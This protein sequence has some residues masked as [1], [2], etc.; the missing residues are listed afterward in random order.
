[1]HLSDAKGV[2]Q[3]R[4]NASVRCKGCA[5]MA[6]KCICQMQRVCRNGGEMH[7]T[8]AKGAEKFAANA[9]A[10]CKG[11]RFAGPLHLAGAFPQIYY[12]TCYSW[13]N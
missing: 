7:L 4:G 6:G 13:V 1:M 11:P 8:D 12:T 10:R 5:A 9:P 3:W 2:L